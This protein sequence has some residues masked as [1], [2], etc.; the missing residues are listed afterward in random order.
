[1]NYNTLL[2]RRSLSPLTRN[3]R[4]IFGQIRAFA[5]MASST[6]QQHPAAAL[7]AAAPQD[8][9]KNK[10]AAA[11]K[12]QGQVPKGKKE[13]KILML[14]GYTQSGTLFSAKTKGLNKLLVK[15][16]SAAPPLDLHPTL[17]Y[18]TGPH[19]LRPSDIPGYQGDDD[20]LDEDDLDNWAWWRKNDATGT[21]TGF[22]AGMLAVAHAIR[23]SGGVDGVMGFSQGGCMAALVAAALEQHPPH[24]PPHSP[25]TSS[26]PEWL[27][28][29][30]TSNAHRPLKFCI[31]Y[32]GFAA[33]PTT[34]LEWLYEPPISTPTLHFIGSNDQIVVPERSEALI[35]RCRDPLVFTHPGTHFV[36]VAREWA[37]P[38]VG[39]IRERCLKD[40]DREKEKDKEGETSSL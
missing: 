10:K 18:P 9:N 21:Y 15:G 20:A 4:F 30:R 11:S 3:S 22:E 7:P 8:K 28:A 1:M 19:R 35:K 31:I 26:S 14:H 40:V 38:L 36:P 17:I 39:W 5:P 23:D 37:M 16:L 24:N 32:S 13:L 33:P 6:E 25:S 2:L 12:G 27:T 34:G 29:L